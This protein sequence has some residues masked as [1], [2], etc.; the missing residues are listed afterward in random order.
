MASAEERF[1]RIKHDNSFP[2]NAISFVLIL[3]NSMNEVDEVVFYENQFEIMTE[4]FT[5]TQ[6]LSQKCLGKLHRYDCTN[7]LTISYKL[8]VHSRKTYTT[9]KPIFMLAT[10][11]LTQLVPTIFLGIKSLS[12]LH[13]MVLVRGNDYCGYGS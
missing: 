11:C 3:P 4:Y 12:L 5:S 1:T 8:V 9:K 2:T 6:I 7:G 13:S 10:I